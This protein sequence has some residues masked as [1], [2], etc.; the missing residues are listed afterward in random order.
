MDPFTI[1]GAAGIGAIGNLAGG[2]IGSSGAQQANAQTAQYNMIEAQKNRDWQE[3]M[4]NTAYQR[5]MQDM[6]AAGL[7]PILAYQQGGAGIGSGAQAQ[8]KFDNAMEHLGQG[9]SSASKGAERAL[10]LQNV[11]A[12]TSSSSSQADVN[13][14]TVGLTEAKKLQSLQET[15]TNARIAANYD[16]DTQL[17]IES[18]GN[19]A[20]MRKQMEANAFNQ[21]AYGHYINQKRH[22][23]RYGDT[24][25]GR[26]FTGGMEL[27]KSAD[28]AI[29]NYY[30]NN[31][32]YLPGHGPG[33]GK[34]G[35]AP[36]LT[37]DMKK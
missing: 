28:E 33:S 17:K 12:Q 34:P 36:P 25:L 9:V 3:R 8:T 16:A 18:S 30:K 29:T 32:V 5:A 37:I 14:A 19:P 13:K 24:K 26:A 21:T 7:N 15:A 23:E 11:A 10:E 27:F 22:L 4:A 35:T 20:A 2:L 31:P 6:R 1:L